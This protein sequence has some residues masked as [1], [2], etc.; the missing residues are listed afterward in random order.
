MFRLSFLK[1]ENFE[2]IITISK[3]RGEKSS[4]WSCSSKKEEASN[5]K[6]IHT[7]TLKNNTLAKIIKYATLKTNNIPPVMVE[8]C[9]EVNPRLFLKLLKKIC[10]IGFY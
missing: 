10:D 4:V 9:L 7:I 2:F 1:N 3:G 5:F 6:K 8:Q